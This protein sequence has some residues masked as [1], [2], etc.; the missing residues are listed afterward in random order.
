[1]ILKFGKQVK[2]PKE[3]IGFFLGRDIFW[4]FQRNLVVPGFCATGKTHKAE[5]LQEAS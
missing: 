5:I 3:A 4:W 1:V 2:D